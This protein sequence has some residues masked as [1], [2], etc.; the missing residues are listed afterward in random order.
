MILTGTTCLA[1]APSMIC[2]T[3]LIFRAGMLTS[4]SVWEMLN[5]APIQTMEGPRAA[6]VHANGNP[7]AEIKAMAAASSERRRGAVPLT[8]KGGRPRI[9]GAEGRMP[10]REPEWTG[11]ATLLSCPIWLGLTRTRTLALR[12]R[13]TGR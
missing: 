6:L 7:T 2:K 10:G 3:S 4:S 5:E 8:K 9:P 11:Q 13:R 12:R 1:N